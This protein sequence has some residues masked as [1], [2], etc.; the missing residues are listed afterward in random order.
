MKP[1][2]ASGAEAAAGK[3]RLAL[4]SNCMASA[5]APAP[6]TLIE[7]NRY[8]RMKSFL[9]VKPGTEEHPEGKQKAHVGRGGYKKINSF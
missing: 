4:R 2:Q 7:G 3:D 6:A 9:S 5:P 8:R 1:Q